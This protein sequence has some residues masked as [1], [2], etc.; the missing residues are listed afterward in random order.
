MKIQNVFIASLALFLLVSLETTPLAAEN[1]QNDQEEFN[2]FSMG[3]SGG[4]IT[5]FTDVKE[6]PFFPDGDEIT[7][8]GR[9][10]LN[11]HLSPVLTMQTNFLYGE[12][13]GVDTEQGLKFE[14]DLLEATLNARIS[15]NTLFKPESEVNQKVNF[16]GFVG[17]GLLAYRSR[18]L[19]D[20]TPINYYGYTDDGY[21]K[22]DLKPELVVPYGLGI[23][24][25]I[26][27]RFDIGLE[28]GF[29]YTS[30]D[31]LDALPHRPDGKDIYNFTSIGLTFRLG[32]NTN[33]MDWAPPSKAMYPGQRGRIDELEGRLD[34]FEE[35]VD[36]LKGQ[37][38]RHE[39]DLNEVMVRVD[40]ISEEKA[41]IMQRTVRLFG[42][43]EDLAD[44][45]SKL[46]AEVD[47]IRTPDHYYAVQVLAMQEELSLEEARQLLGITHDIQMHYID[48][49]YKYTSGKYHNLEDAILHMQRI[50]GQGV[51]DAFIVEYRDGMLRP[52]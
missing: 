26:S 21:T 29:R 11:Y 2:R 43:V 27:E 18:L 40:G 12:L 7:F 44:E 16:Y 10:S 20:G 34:A 31:R 15:F 3:L 30:S 13:E 28:T 22:D 48:G 33:S 46:S 50:W 17:A 32:S 9:L 24:F 52:R 8:G 1:N 35:D 47:Q 37:Y 38:D 36:G 23:N 45:I 41:E 6:N 39:Q 42:A 14:T 51:R 49:Y 19:Q 4:A 25:K 5:S